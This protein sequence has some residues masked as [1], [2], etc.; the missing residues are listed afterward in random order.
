MRKQILE[1]LRKFKSSKLLVGICILHILIMI[2]G[3]F[4]R[5]KEPVLTHLYR[6]P[7]A[8]VAVFLYTFFF[9]YG[10]IVIRMI[11]SEFESYV[12]GDAIRA[13]VGRKQ[14]FCVKCITVV[15]VTAVLELLMSLSLL[16]TATIRFGKL[17]KLSVDD[18]FKF[19]GFYLII[20]L[21]ILIMDS[22]AMLVSYICKHFGL[23]TAVIF[24]LFVIVEPRLVN[25]TGCATPLGMVARAAARIETDELYMFGS[26]FWVALIPGIIIGVAAVVA[27]YIIFMK[28]E[29]AS[30]EE[31]EAE[32]K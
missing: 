32:Q 14:Y 4:I 10:L 25:A 28:T 3:G 8:T 19:I 9:L 29:F 21:L 26:E 5:F 1:E 16:V 23:S 30:V 24:I 6:M 17:P 13:G 12:V 15:I 22:I 27:S 20:V 2:V 31:R 18:I 11:A 7:I